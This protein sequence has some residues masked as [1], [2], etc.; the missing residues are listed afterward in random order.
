[1]RIW[2]GRPGSNWR[3]SAWEDGGQLKTMNIAFPGISFC[4]R[5]YGNLVIRFPP[6]REWSTNG[7]HD[8]RCQL[9]VA[10][11]EINSETVLNDLDPRF[12]GGLSPVCSGFPPALPPSF[13]GQCSSTCCRWTRR[14]AGR[15]R[16]THTTKSCLGG[17]RPSEPLSFLA[18]CWKPT[19][20]RSFGSPVILDAP[21]SSTV[22]SAK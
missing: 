14:C 3:H 21:D 1:M 20:C 18:V 8:I 4:N 17:N 5:N 16:Q 6:R 15:E 10:A 19:L 11:R 9:L 7:A 13:D 2:S 12:G 22:K